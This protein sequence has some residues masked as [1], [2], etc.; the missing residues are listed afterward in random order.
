VNGAAI[1]ETHPYT[2]GR[3]QQLLGLSRHAIGQFIALG[4]VTPL[5]PSGRA[6]RFSFRDLVVLRAAHELQRAQVPVRQ[7]LRSLRRLR[8]RLPAEAPLHGLRIT[9]VGDRVTVREGGAQWEADTGQALLDFTVGGTPAALQFVARGSA[10]GPAASDDESAAAAHAED[11]A[12]ARF[13]AAETLEE[14]DPAAAEAAYRALIAKVPAHVNAYLNL[15]FMLCEAGRCDEAA[16]LYDAALA[17]VSDDALLHYNRAVALEAL[18]RRREALAAYR[19]CLRL[20]PALAD[21]HQNAALLYAEEG[22][23]KMAIRHFSAF[24]RLSASDL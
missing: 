13:D 2:L 1:D 4:L 11:D 3:L 14:S 12:Q 22:D 18:G 20:A 17:H 21:A 23:K 16:T 6:Y 9:A 8:E 15:G 5:R 19:E 24:R 7:L 10:D